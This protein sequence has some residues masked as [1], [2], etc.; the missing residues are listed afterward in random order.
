MPRTL[1]KMREA[2]ARLSNQPCAVSGC[3]GNRLGV[4]RYCKKHTT[5]A[6]AYGHPN[7]F[8]IPQASYQQELNEVRELFK[9]HAD[10]PGLISVMQWMDNWIEEAAKG[11]ALIGN[12]IFGRIHVK[13]IQGRE[14][15]TT[16]DILAE[17]AAIWVYAQ[18]FPQR[19]PDDQRLTFA[20][21]RNVTRLAT[22]E[23]RAY[24]P[25]KQV[26]SRR[27]PVAELRGVGERIRQTLGLFLINVTESLKRKAEKAKG[28]KDS[29][30]IPF[31]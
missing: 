8:P 19:L 18:R 22:M 5:K 23:K 14:G 9:E 25:S 16:P 13:R 3:T 20:I 31:E 6:Y 15:L 7:G 29:L 30:S 1:G 11:E 10:H 2:N 28:F 26:V 24:G 17:I 27:P 12:Y 21:S 4:A